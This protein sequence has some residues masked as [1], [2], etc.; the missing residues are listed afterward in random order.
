[1]RG[2]SSGWISDSFT[3]R[4]PSVESNPLLLED[5]LA[6]TFSSTKVF[7]S[8]QAGHLPIH[9][10]DSYPHELQKYTDFIFVLAIGDIQFSQAKVEGEG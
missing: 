9:L 5:C 3:G 1:M 6:D 2:S 4:D 10:G 7:H 8:P